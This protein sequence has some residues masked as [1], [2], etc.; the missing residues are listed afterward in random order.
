MIEECENALRAIREDNTS[1]ASEL[2]HRAVQCLILFSETSEDPSP[3]RF[4]N[5]L[6]DFMHRI[7]SSQPAMAPFFNLANVVL[8]GIEDAEDV[9]GIKEAI[10]EAA[11]TFLRGLRE[12][13]RRIAIHT[14]SLLSGKDGILTHSFSFTVFEA[15]RYASNAGRV[16]RVICTESRPALEGVN[17]AKQ[18]AVEGVEVH[19]ALDSAAPS[20]LREVD[21]L[22]TGGDALSP[23]GL[24]NKIGTYGIAVAAKAR[25]VPFYALCGTDKILTEGLAEKLRIEQKD[26]V[27]V[28]PTPHPGVEVINHYFDITPI[29]FLSGVVTEE[30]VWQR[31]QLNRFVGGLRVC[32][33]LREERI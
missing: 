13:P 26:S 4:K 33:A 31:D 32:K 19:L 5:D 8:M 22:L 17:L 21:L 1:G 20:L 9:E 2:V 3:S 18:L 16:L 10:G 12:I 24:V 7:I 6:L 27:E 14:A 15:I 23:L 25:G 29:E 11:S 30:G 28:L